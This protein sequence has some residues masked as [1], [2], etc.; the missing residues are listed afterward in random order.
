MWGE[1]RGERGREVRCIICVCLAYLPEALCA[2]LKKT[3]SVLA[4][5]GNSKRRRGG[6][7]K[8]KEEEGE[9]GDRG[10][11]GEDEEEDEDDEDEEEEEKEAEKE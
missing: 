5:K 1:G 11:L 4:V 9:E 7:N 8:I 10:G 3:V 6:R 2:K